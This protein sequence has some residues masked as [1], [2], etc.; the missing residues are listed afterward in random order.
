[1][2]ITAR[3]TPADGPTAQKYITRR[4]FRGSPWRH[5]PF[6]WNFLWGFLIGTGGML[7]F[8]FTADYCGPTD[9]RLTCGLGLLLGGVLVLATASK[10]AQ[11]ASR[12]VLFRPGGSS[13]GPQIFT[14][15][16]TALVQQ[17][18]TGEIKTV[19]SA[20]EGIEEDKNYL[21]LFLDRGFATFIPRRAFPDQSAYQEFAALIN[22]HVS[23]AKS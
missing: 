16:D 3:Y 12:K 8:R 5:V 2:E 18:N 6:F 19:W 14:V 9:R 7:L 17:S 23:A 4:M 11:S 13:F 22:R 1:M 10:V 21:Y 15:T 20:F